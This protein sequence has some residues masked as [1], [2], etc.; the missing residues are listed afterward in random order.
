MLNSK[1]PRMDSYDT[2]NK[3]YSQG[4]YGKFTFVL[5]LISLDAAMINP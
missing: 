1:G 4:L 5:C 2:P 3:I